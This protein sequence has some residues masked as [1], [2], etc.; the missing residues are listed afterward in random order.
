MKISITENEA[1]DFLDDETLVLMEPKYNAFG[2]MVSKVPTGKI[3][4][5]N[6][7]IEL[8]IEL[9]RYREVGTV[10]EC[11]EAVQKTKK[12]KTKKQKTKKPNRT[13][14][15]E[16]DYYTCPNCGQAIKWK[17]GEHRK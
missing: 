14:R 3:A 12:R 6:G 10:E 5:L 17:R 1:I 7:I 13:G 4:K 15:D 8:I 11:R 2:K 16:Q 9:K